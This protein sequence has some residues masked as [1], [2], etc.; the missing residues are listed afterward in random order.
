MS[1]D[2]LVLYWHY[3]G[4]VL[5]L[6]LCCTATV[7]LLALRW[8]IDPRSQTQAAWGV[9]CINIMARPNAPSRTH[10]RAHTI[11]VSAG[12]LC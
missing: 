3:P 7:L 2:V 10:M 6:L 12:P 11:P 5:V 1:C 8:N 4:H 9:P